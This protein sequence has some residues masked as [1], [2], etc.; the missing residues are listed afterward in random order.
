LT[1]TKRIKDKR[2]NEVGQEHHVELAKRGEMP[3][4]VRDLTDDEAT[5]IMVDSAELREKDKPQASN[6]SKERKRRNRRS[7]DTPH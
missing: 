5:I 4:I 1:L 7:K 3:C 6:N 2:E